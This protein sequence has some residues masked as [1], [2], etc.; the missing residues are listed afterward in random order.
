[1]PRRPNPL[2]LPEQTAPGTPP[3]AWGYIYFKTNGYACYKGDDGNEIALGGL[4][5]VEHGSTAATARPSGQGPILWVGSVVPTN[6]IYKD[7]FLYYPSNTAGT[8]RNTVASLWVF[9][10]TPTNHVAV[11][12]IGGGPSG[13]GNLELAPGFE[14]S[15]TGAGWNGFFTTASIGNSTDF[16]RTGLQS[17]K[18][19]KSGSAGDMY[20]YKH[21]SVYN[22][23]VSE[24]EYVCTQ[25]WFRPGSTVRTIGLSIQFIANRSDGL[26]TI[27]QQWY[28]RGITEISGQWVMAQAAGIVPSGATYARPVI[29]WPSCAASEVHYV[30]DIVTEKGAYPSNP[31]ILKIKEA[32]V[33]PDADLTPAEGQIYID[34]TVGSSKIMAKMKDSAGTVVTHQLGGTSDLFPEIS[35]PATPATGFVA[36]YAKSN[37]QL[38]EKDDTGLESP[39]T[40]NY[41]VCTSSTRPAS[42]YAGLTIFETDTALSYYYHNSTWIVLEKDTTKYKSADQSVSSTTLADDTHLSY[43]LGT[44]RYRLDGCLWVFSGATTT[45]AAISLNGSSTVATNGLR[46]S[47]IGQITQGASGAASTFFGNTITGYEAATIVGASVVGTSA[48]TPSLILLKGYLNLSGAGTLILRIAAEVAASITYMEGSWMQVTKLT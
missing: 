31:G 29:T 18:V 17:L 5:V 14:T 48:A 25:A 27:V 12:W 33:P 46:F 37:G 35:T 2:F 36:V 32:Y 44:G 20:C 13:L 41:V 21:D 3:S 40:S 11:Q 28:G 42:P 30:D 22:I 23:P 10:T 26:S 39:L 24:G 1:M 38:Y 8:T 4:F 15:Q 34:P 47:A 6:A 45:G 19:T 9:N 43:V 16:A 7:Q